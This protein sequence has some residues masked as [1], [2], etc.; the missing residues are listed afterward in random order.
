M[1]FGSPN[2]F[3]ISLDF[4]ETHVDPHIRALKNVD[5]F[6]AL[7]ARIFLNHVLVLLS[8][9]YNHYEQEA[10]AV[11]MTLR[12][13]GDPPDEFWKPETL[14]WIVG[15]RA[16]LAGD[17]CDLSQFI[18]ANGDFLSHSMRQPDMDLLHF[19]WDVGNPIGDVQRP[20]AAPSPALSAHDVRMTLGHAQR[21]NDRLSDR[22][23]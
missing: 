18:A 4:C 3:S 8:D 6:R 22:I 21:P 20:P 7:A 14:E 13:F 19:N 1:S 23:L 17:I 10:V 15:A 16:R 2:R 5:T 9:R 12:A 11:V